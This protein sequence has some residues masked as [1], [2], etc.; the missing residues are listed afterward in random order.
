M[1]ADSVVNANIYIQFILNA[2]MQAIYW[3]K[4]INYTPSSLISHSN[5][6]SSLEIR[7]RELVIFSKHIAPSKLY[8]IYIVIIDF[9]NATATHWLLKLAA[10]I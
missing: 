2:I 1:A 10:L 6:E 5:S 3:W 9:Q 7:L 4:I 8:L